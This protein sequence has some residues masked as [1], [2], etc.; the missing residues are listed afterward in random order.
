MNRR[1]IVAL[2]VSAFVLPGAVDA[3][4]QVSFDSKIKKMTHYVG[5]VLSADGSDT[6]AFV[7]IAV[8]PSPIRGSIEIA[9]YVCDGTPMGQFQYYRGLVPDEGGSPLL[10]LSAE[11]T[12]SVRIDGRT[13]TGTIAIADG[14]TNRFTATKMTNGGGF[15][16]MTLMPDGQFFGDLFRARGRIR[17]RITENGSSTEIVGEFIRIGSSVLPFDGFLD[18]AGEPG[19]Y[20]LIIAEDGN[21]LGASHRPYIEQDTAAPGT[22]VRGQFTVR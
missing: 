14:S 8:G 18:I 4:A 19:D 6:G 15:Y 11:T 9:G 12:L 16:T 2:L 1:T 10:S 3:R 17:G 5:H 21:I 20:R 7:A 22:T 13:A